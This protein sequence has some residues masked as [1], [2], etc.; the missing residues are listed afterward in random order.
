M[1]CDIHPLIEYQPWKPR[2]SEAPTWW[3]WAKGNFGI[4]RSYIAFSALAGVRQ[5]EGHPEAV[6]P[7]RG[8]PKDW[9]PENEGADSPDWHSHSWLTLPEVEEAHRRVVAWLESYRLLNRDTMDRKS[10]LEGVLTCLRFLASEGVEA[11]F[12]F[13][14]DN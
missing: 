1:G 4:P 3:T 10:G 7:P 14:F 12:V 5:Y 13:W 2:E 6:C 11:R 8:L 9:H